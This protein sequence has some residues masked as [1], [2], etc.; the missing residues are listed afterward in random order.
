MARLG[1]AAAPR[2]DISVSARTMAECDQ[3]FDRLA[4]PPANALHGVFRGRLAAVP[5]L[6]SLPDRTR[7]AITS[8]ASHLRFPW[9]GKAFD[10]DHGANVW[11]TSTGHFQ[12]FGYRVQYGERAAHLSYQRAENPRLLRGLAAEIRSLASGRYLCRAA[13][14]GTVVLYFTL[15]S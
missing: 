7:R 12:R 10:G 14:R 8:I 9:Y 3:L 2:D 13:L 5:A 15:E 11:L 6:D 4:A 1:R